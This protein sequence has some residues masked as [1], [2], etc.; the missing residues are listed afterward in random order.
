MW[1]V[2]LADVLPLTLGAGGGGLVGDR[3]GRRAPV[4]LTL[5]RIGREGRPYPAP[6]PS[7]PVHRVTL[8][9]QLAQR[10]VQRRQAPGLS[11]KRARHHA[12]GQEAQHAGGAVDREAEELDQQL[13]DEAGARQ[14]AL[15]LAGER[16]LGEH[17]DSFYDAA[18]L[19][20]HDD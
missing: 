5:E 19:G 9:V 7:L 10:L 20:A 8:D 11:A 12:R 4:P 2:A 3:A 1:V 16:E 17:V 14:G 18:A 15:Q 6:H 13:R